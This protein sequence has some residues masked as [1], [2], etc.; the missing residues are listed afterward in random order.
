M[1]NKNFDVAIIGSGPGGYVAAIKASQLGLSTALIESSAIGGICLNWGCIP[2]KALLRNAE[3]LNLFRRSEE[4]GISYT[5]LKYD[6]GKGISRSRRVVNR[7]TRGINS[8]LEKNGIAIIDGYAQFK[9]AH[10]LEIEN[11]SNIVKAE[12]VIIATGARQKAIAHMEVDGSIIITSREALELP[13]VPSSLLILGGGATGV[14]FA[15]LYASYGAD[16]TLVELKDNLLPNEDEEIS[17]QLAYALTK[18]GIKVH[19][20]TT[21]V[22]VENVSSKVKVTLGTP[23]G[24]TQLICE[25]VLVAAGIEGNTDNIGLENIGIVTNNSFVDVNENMQ[26]NIHTIYA[27]GDVT[28]KMPLAHVAS[29]QAILAVEHIAGIPT[30]PINYKNMP[31]ATYCNPQVASF[32]YTEKEAQSLG[33]EVRIGKFP[34]RANGKALAIGETD[35]MIKIIFNARNDS[36]IGA[37]MIGSDVTEMLAEISMTNKL[38]GTFR[39]LGYMTHSHPTLSEMLKEAGLDAYG[40]SIHT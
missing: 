20:N 39:D 30:N 18:L 10:T 2:S 34:F 24:N 15:Y 22:A 37:H 33:I 9:D 3:V 13:T 23:T 38:N 32:G 7:L 40:E 8:L 28:G 6:F 29:A 12:N 17:K 31:K 5:D 25:K 16:V 21:V 1:L 11:T 26:T 4:F 19:T 27:I 14:E 36:I 35:G